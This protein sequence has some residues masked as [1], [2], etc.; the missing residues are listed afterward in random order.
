MQKPRG[1]RQ[2]DLIPVLGPN[3]SRS[4]ATQA[5]ADPE[6]LKRGPQTKK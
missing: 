1:C 2:A 6:F 4:A 5:L 3:P